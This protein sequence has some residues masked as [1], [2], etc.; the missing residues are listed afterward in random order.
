LN[1]LV[2][3]AVYGAGVLWLIFTREP[4]GVELRGKMAGY[5]QA[6]N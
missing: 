3:G 5:F 6:G 2:G 4:M 1:L